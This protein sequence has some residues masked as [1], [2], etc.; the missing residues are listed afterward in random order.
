M[1]LDTEEIAMETSVKVMC[2]VIRWFNDVS[3]EFTASVVRVS[4]DDTLNL[5]KLL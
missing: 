2:S 1:E 3:E 5:I 4:F